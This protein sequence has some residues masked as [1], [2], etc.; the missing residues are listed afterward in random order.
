MKTCYY[1]FVCDND[2]GECFGFF[3]EDKKKL[4]CIHWFGCNDAI[5]RH[6]YMSG[7]FKHLGVKMASLPEK[8]HTTALK[9]LKKRMGIL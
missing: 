1:L 9:L 6:E 5:Y 8:M 7:L 2:L 3:T 4:T